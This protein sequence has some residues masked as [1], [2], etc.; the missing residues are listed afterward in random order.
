IIFQ[1]G[2][3]Q[4]G[5]PSIMRDND[6]NVAA[7]KNYLLSTI[8][9]K[10]STFFNITGDW[11]IRAFV[12]DG[13]VAPPDAGVDAPVGGPCSANPDCPI[14]EFCDPSSHTCTFECRNAADCGGGTCNSLGMCV[15]N[16]GGGGGCCQTGEGGSGGSLLTLGVL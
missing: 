3:N 10:K 12:S 11:V 4:P 14:S 8:G 7:D 9:W 15:A 16:N 2:A 5:A 13:G 6:G 1:A